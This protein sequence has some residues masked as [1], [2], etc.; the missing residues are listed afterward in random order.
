LYTAW[1]SAER[2]EQSTSDSYKKT[3]EEQEQE[4][5]K[6][7][8]WIDRKVLINFHWVSSKLILQALYLWMDLVLLLLVL[9]VSICYQNR[10]EMIIKDYSR[11]AGKA[12]G[13]IC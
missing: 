4:R 12:R 2:E 13:V 5:K 10:R 9:K 7:T 6:C 8:G 11:V 3:K 1:T